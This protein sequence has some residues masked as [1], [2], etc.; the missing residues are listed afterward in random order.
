MAIFLKFRKEW[1][2]WL[3][4][5]K[6]KRLALKNPQ[7]LRRAKAASDDD[8]S[9]REDGATVCFGCTL[10][11]HVCSVYP[12]QPETGEPLDDDF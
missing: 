8:D 10:P 5:L 7:G 2:A 3:E 6:K 11:I 12:M 9:D 1:E 4:S